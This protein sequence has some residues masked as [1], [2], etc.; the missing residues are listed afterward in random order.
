MTGQLGSGFGSNTVCR[1]WLQV[2]LAPRLPPLQI[3]ASGLPGAGPQLPCASAPPPR[4]TSRG[5]WPTVCTSRRQDLMLS[6]SSLVQ[7][8]S[9]KCPDFQDKV[10]TWWGCGQS[11]ICLL[12]KRSLGPCGPRN[13]VT[14]ACLLG[15]YLNLFFKGPVCIQPRNSSSAPH[16][17]RTEF[18]TGV[19]VRHGCPA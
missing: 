16:Q 10:Q 12:L 7:A 6:L 18:G 14:D 13:A 3:L 8:S 4:P 9:D 1:C 2:T 17:H 19:M 11:R 5:P 15:N